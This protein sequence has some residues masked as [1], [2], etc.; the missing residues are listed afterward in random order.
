MKDA[1][2]I[3]AMF[4]AVGPLDAGIAEVVRDTDDR[5]IVRLGTVEVEATFD[6][7]AQ[8]L[9]FAVEIGVPPAANRESLYAVLLV[10]NIAGRE[11]D[12]VTM[13]LTHP[14]GTIVQVA[15]RDALALTAREI[16]AICVNLSERALVWRAYVAI[17]PAA[18]KAPP[19][20]HLFSEFII[21]A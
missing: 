8:R 20:G 10:Y 11:T 12:D 1:A 13:A 4:A 15:V 19:T 5:W 14:G 16:A 21:R 7:R 6:P 9:R 18:G 2:A 3:D 17:G